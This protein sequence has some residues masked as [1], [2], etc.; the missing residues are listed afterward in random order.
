MH[1]LFFLL[2][3]SAFDSLFLASSRQDT[4][5]SHLPY[6]MIHSRGP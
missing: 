6:V 3:H 2:F 4:K 1:L 5:C